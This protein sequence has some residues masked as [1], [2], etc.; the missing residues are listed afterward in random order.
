MPLLSLSQK[1]L[2]KLYLIHNIH[3]EFKNLGLTIHL[4][5]KNENALKPKHILI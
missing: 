1:M 2:T 5:T 3:M 4:N